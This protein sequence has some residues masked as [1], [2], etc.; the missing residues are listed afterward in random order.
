MTVTTVKRSEFRTF[1]NTGTI[2]VPVWS[3]LGEGIT[4][5]EI[6]YNPQTVEETYIHENSGNTEVESYKPTLPIEAVAK[7]GDAVFEYID[8][9]RKSR[10]VL[11]SAHTE[12]VNVWMYETPTTGA[13][14]AEK[15][16][17]GIQIDSFGGEG[18]QSAKINFTINF[19]GDAISGT[20]NPTTLAWVAS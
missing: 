2:A 11:S 14:P 6:N 12:I 18:G 16:D 17:V 7:N 13:Y 1:L 15:Q 9:M 8:A 5:A 3:L 4:A 20:F 10:A 19:L